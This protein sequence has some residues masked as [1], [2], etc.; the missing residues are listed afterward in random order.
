LQSLPQADSFF[1]IIT[2]AEEEQRGCQLSILMKQ[3]GKKVFDRLTRK[4][5]M[6][7]WREPDV[8]RVAPVPLY[9]S[10]E[11][12]FRFVELFRTAISR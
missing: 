10:F 1:S 2:P 4:G 6:A 5:V 8:I 3:N 11:D 12:V 9:N 7:D